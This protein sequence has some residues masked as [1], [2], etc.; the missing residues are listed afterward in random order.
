MPTE[1]QR[2]AMLAAMGIDVYRLRASPATAVPLRVGVDARTCVCVDGS[3]D[4]S[5]ERLLAMLPAVLGIARERVSR[6]IVADDGAIVVDASAL[7]ANGA[8]KRVLWQSL[9][10][11]ARRLREN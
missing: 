7:R 6:D 8:A 9:K 3:D 5:V 11:L 10:P 1:A 2:S 4:A